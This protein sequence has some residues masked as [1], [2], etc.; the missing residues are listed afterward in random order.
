MIRFFSFQTEEMKSIAV[1]SEPCSIE[2]I[3]EP[4]EELK[5]KAVV[6]DKDGEAIQYIKEPSEQIQLAS[7]MSNGSSIQYIE[8]HLKLYNLQL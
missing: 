2:H 1:E 8:N 5:L 3:I 4:S 6:M 7:V